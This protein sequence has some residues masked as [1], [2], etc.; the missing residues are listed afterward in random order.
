MV[1]LLQNTQNRDTRAL[2]LKLDELLRAVTGARPNLVNLENL[3][4]E[5]LDHLQQEFERLHKRPPHTE[6]NY[7]PKPALQPR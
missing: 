5:E 4:D 2:H 3:S 6:V 7:E 1:F